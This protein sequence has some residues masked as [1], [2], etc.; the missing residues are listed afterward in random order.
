MLDSDSKGSLLKKISWLSLKIAVSAGVIYFTVYQIEFVSLY[1]LWLD[2]DAGWILLSIALM[3]ASYFAGAYQWMRILKISQFQLPY[4][5]ILGYYYVG[6]FFNNFLISGMGGDFLRVYDI[7]QHSENKDRLS[8]A[9]ATVFFDRFVGFITLVFL[10]S[11]T[12]LFEIGHGASLR[13]VLL[14]VALFLSWII[15][16]IALFNK[17]VAE[18]TIK[19]L[20][21]LLPEKIYSRFQHLYYEINRFG[22]AHK[23]LLYIF[24]ISLSVQIQRILAIWAIGRALGDTSQ[25][26]YYVIFVPLIAVVASLPISIGGTGPREQTTVILFRRIGVSREIAFSIGFLAYIVSM[27][28]TLPGALIFIIRKGKKH[29]A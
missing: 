26:V 10:A 22:S 23:E 9:L 5:R 7:H 24:M 28:T 6:L 25:L 4:G 16:M 14:I 1:R 11:L 2:M 17:S 8:P 18:W 21:K 29:D 20:G 27:I 12:G 13:M 15:L 3:S 19:P